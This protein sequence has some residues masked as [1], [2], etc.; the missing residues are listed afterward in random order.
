MIPNGFFEKDGCIWK[1]DLQITNGVI[2]DVQLL[3]KRWGNKEEYYA[4]VKF[5]IGPMREMKTK[6]LSL[7][8]LRGR[9]LMKLLPDGFILMNLSEQKKVWFIS[10]Y[11]NGGLLNKKP[12]VVHCLTAGYN[13][14]QNMYVYLL[15]DRL[16]RPK[17]I[18]ERVCIESGLHLKEISNKEI[19][20]GWTWKFMRLKEEVTPTL[21]LAGAVIPVLRPFLQAV[22]IDTT[23]VTYVVGETGTGKSSLVKLLTE[24]YK[25][26]NYWTVSSDM[27]DL[28]GGMNLIQDFPFLLDDLN[29]TETSRVKA[30][31]ES[32][33]SEIIQQVS[34][35]DVVAS[36]GVCSHFN[37]NLIVTAEYTL[38]N[39]STMNRCIVLNMLSCLDME[40]LGTLKRT[41]ENYIQL[42]IRFITWLCAE[43]DKH[44]EVI[45]VLNESS[46]TKPT[47][48]RQAYAGIVR[49]E[50]TEKILK[51]GMEI[52]L[53]FLEEE[54]KMPEQKISEFRKF[55]GASVTHCIDDTRTLVRKED[56]DRGREYVDVIVK[57]FTID[58]GEVKENYKKYKKARARGDD[59]VI[60]FCSGECVCVTGKDLVDLFEKEQ[61]FQYSI[62][63][64]AISAQLMY[65]GMLK[66]SGGECSFPCSE[67][68]DKTRYYHIYINK[69]AEMMDERQLK[70]AERYSPFLGLYCDRY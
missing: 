51:I 18:G 12:E 22:G 2:Q 37:G 7:Q 13:I 39:I 52:F 50:R 61:D 64:K 65:H 33:V 14:V 15:G 30:S 5:S 38:K 29:K 1:G 56:I 16:I 10:E 66:V 17:G 32:K 21:F 31:K 59:E 45:Q 67:S 36:K 68:N 55:F 42:L 40:V 63:K 46:L 43:K 70:L 34:N 8:E 60:F 28:R 41:Q 27:A 6:E 53:R 58:C 62:S 25:E 48:N 57:Q 47:Y 19:H 3:A 20:V 26:K 35:H 24:I 11:I 44:M 4:E 69:I 9:N 23:F 54:L 49:I